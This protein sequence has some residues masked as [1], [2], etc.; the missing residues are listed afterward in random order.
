MTTHGERTRLTP[1]ADGHKVTPAEL[2]FDLVFVYAIT[3][4]TALMA[5]DATALRLLGGMVVL[6]LLWW[7]WCCFAWL[8]NVVRADSGGM[9]AVLVSVM[10]VVL[11]VSLTVPEVYDDAP[12]GLPAPL[13][14]VLCYGAVRA[15]HLITYWLSAP[16]DKPLRATLRRTALLSVLP[17]F[18]LLLV[19]AAF[20]GVTQIL[21]WLAA[22]TIDYL[23]IFITGKSGW[24]VASPAH[25]SERHG[26]IVIIAL[27]ESI[28]AIG[29][30]VTGYPVT[31][32]V[33]A[34][35]ALGLLISAALWRLYFHGVSEP[36]EHRLAQLTGDARTTLA[37]DV[38]TFLHLPL[39]AGVVITALGMKKTLQQVADTEHYGL[40]EPLHGMPAWALAGGVGLFLLASA[41]ILLR[42]AGHR[43]PALI[44][45]GVLCLAAGP[46]V[47]LVPALAALTALVAAVTALLILHG[48]TTHTAAGASRGLAAG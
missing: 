17:P 32:P 36:T 15:L 43:S 19:G 2:F 37:R 34:A 41:A 26:L 38:Y 44:T 42:T 35:A 14:F 33:V 27:G 29:V 12:G 24:R 30:G 23:G 1:T 28:V 6:A 5:A 39:V 31:I 8:G 48:R 4:V 9:F 10:T 7:C 22:V 47:A 3:Q 11:I 45:G 13:L 46:V 25:F 18:A 40:A 21:I 20:E 16:D